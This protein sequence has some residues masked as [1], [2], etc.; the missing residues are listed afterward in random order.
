MGYRPFAFGQL[1]LHGAAVPGTQMDGYTPLL[2]FQGQ[3]LTTA[4]DLLGDGVTLEVRDG[5]GVAVAVD[6]P[7]PVAVMVLVGVIC[8]PLVP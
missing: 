7:V 6:V 5:D 2:G 1:P 4:G 8:D 3:P